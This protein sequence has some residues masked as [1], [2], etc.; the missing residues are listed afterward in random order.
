M[1]AL[2]RLIQ[3]PMTRPSLLGAVLAVV[4]GVGTFIY[5][6]DGEADAAKTSS[7]CPRLYLGAAS[8]VSSPPT[9]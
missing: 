5:L 4:V 3:L 7:G 9:R 6:G 1:P 2:K 8:F